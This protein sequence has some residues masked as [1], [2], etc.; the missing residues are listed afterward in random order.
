MDPRAPC[1]GGDPSLVGKRDRLHAVAQV[2]LHQKID[3]AVISSKHHSATFTF[4]APGATGLQC[5]LRRKPKGGHKKAK[6][7]YSSCTSP[8]TYRHLKIGSYTFFVRAVRS[9]II[10]TAASKSFKI[11]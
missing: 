9:G 2:Q 6:P 3:K 10:G 5:A 7:K 1:G 11:G 8:K 4:R